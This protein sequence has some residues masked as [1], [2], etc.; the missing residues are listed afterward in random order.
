MM[1]PE[2]PEDYITAENPLHLPGGYA[3]TQAQAGAYQ[4]ESLGSECLAFVFGL[5]PWKLL[6][7]QIEKGS[8]RGQ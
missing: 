1:F 5:N 3:G 7:K 8:H 6:S 4:F 2:R